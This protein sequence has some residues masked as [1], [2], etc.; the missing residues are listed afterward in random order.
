MYFY[1]WLGVVTVLAGKL[2]DL[3]MQHDG[4]RF[5]KGS[6]KIW[7]MFWFAVIWSIWLHRNEMIFKQKQLDFAKVIEMVKV[8]IWSWCNGLIKKTPFSFTDWCLDPLYF[9][10]S[11]L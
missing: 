5:C 3:L 6:K 8:R 2:W 10:E 7:R 4:L 11:A 9:M 1:D